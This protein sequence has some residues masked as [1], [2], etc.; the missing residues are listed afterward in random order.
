MFLLDQLPDF[1]R[2]YAFPC[3]L[4]TLFLALPPPLLPLV[5]PHGKVNRM[6]ELVPADAVLLIYRR[7]LKA[8]S[9]IPNGTIKL[10]LLQQIRNGFRKQRGVRSAM[11]QREL[12]NQAHQD[13]MILEDDRHTRTLYINRFGMVSCMEWEVRRTEWHISPRAEKVYQIS[14]LMCTLFFGFLALNTQMVDNAHPDIAETVD[15]M[16]VR[17]EVDDPSELPVKRQ[18]EMALHLDARGRQQSLEERILSTFRDAPQ[19]Q[20]A[21]SP[22]VRNPMASRRFQ[23]PE[24]RSPATVAPEPPRAVGSR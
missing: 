15:L 16:M 6:A 10:L 1:L 5:D 11:A 3:L 14:F 20:P 13:L 19:D 2:L 17:L 23:A 8:A 9:R 4:L 22:T 12:I 21:L 24:E 18:R 7:Y